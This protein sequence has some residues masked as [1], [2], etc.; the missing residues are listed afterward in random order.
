[1]TVSTPTFRT[2]DDIE[3]TALLAAHHVG[4]IAFGYYGRVDIEPI[5]YVWSNGEIY[6][7]T[8]DGTKLRA[9]VANRQV[10]FEID[11]VGAMFD[12]RSVV[13]KGTLVVL[14]ADEA[15]DG[16]W[17]RAVT[18]LRRI[19]PGAFTADDPTPERSIVFRIHAEQLT[20]RSAASA[21][22]G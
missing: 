14:E 1:M 21:P 7:R 16:E 5:H 22:L 2:L 4:R 9:I 8:R 20:G 17:Q 18:H 13:V 19:I 11:E 15:A 12:W 10:A 3:C 6:G